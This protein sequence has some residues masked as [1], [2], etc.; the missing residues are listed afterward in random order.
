MS[1]RFDWSLPEV[2]DRLQSGE[3]AVFAALVREYHPKLL[4]LARAIVGEAGADDV[5]QEAWVSAYKAIA[6][7]ERR[8]SLKT[9]L[10]RI[11]INEARSRLRHES[12]LISLDASPIDDGDPL[13]YRFLED[14]HWADAPVNWDLASPEELLSEAQLQDCL[15]KN[16]GAMP[17][18]QK[19]VISL[20]D[21][22]G[23]E[24]TEICNMLAVSESNVRVLLHR[25]RTRVY[26]MIEHYQ[27]TGEC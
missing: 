10:M 17:R 27:E 21:I 23:L 4:S 26:T 8:A 19:A 9:W 14:G 13:E 22:E 3:Q 25:A 5:V 12:R 20:R 11:V 24:L 16:L 18:M 2:L 7:F 6:R 1:A 15:D